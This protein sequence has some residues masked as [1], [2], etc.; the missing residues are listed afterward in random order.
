MYMY[1]KTVTVNVWCTNTKYMLYM[2]NVG[3]ID[4]II[5]MVQ[6]NTCTF[7]FNVVYTCM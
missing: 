1:S 7:N 3:P 6:Y 4:L 2:Y 5:I